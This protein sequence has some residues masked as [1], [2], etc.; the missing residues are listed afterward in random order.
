LP[1]AFILRPFGAVY[2]PKHSTVIVRK[3]ISRDYIMELEKINNFMLIENNLIRSVSERL[4]ALDAGVR[5]S[6]NL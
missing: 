6:D 2:L 5:P 4:Q 3:A 1:F